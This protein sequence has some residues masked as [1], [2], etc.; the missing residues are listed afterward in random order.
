MSM[1]DYDNQVA[2]D[3]SSLINDGVKVNAI[4]PLKVMILIN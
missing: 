1:T 4:Q 3:T 2:Q